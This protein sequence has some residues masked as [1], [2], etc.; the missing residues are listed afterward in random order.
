MKTKFLLFALIVVVVSSCTMEKRVHQP[1]FYMDW[2]HLFS[3]HKEV[4][5]AKVSSNPASTEDV[6]VAMSSKQSVSVSTVVNEPIHVITPSSVAK[7]EK[8]AVVS[9]IKMNKAT[10]RAI[11]TNDFSNV[12]ASAQKLVSAK[13]QSLSGLFQQSQTGAKPDQ[14]LLVILAILLPPIA[15][16]LYQGRW[17]GTCWLNLI[18]TLLCG[19]PGVIH[20][21]IVVLK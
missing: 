6:A 10:L 4:K 8:K 12:T 21:L 1:G 18:L 9:E 13:A 14:V 15:V 5:T 3:N 16:Y 20:A 17:D 7:A 2:H 19:L 11:R